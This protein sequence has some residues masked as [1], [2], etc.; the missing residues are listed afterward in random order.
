[1]SKIADFIVNDYLDTTYQVDV[2]NENPTYVQ[3]V[4]H[5]GHLEM[6]LVWDKDDKENLFGIYK[7][8]VELTTLIELSN[9]QVFLN[10]II[11]AK[12]NDVWCTVTRTVGLTD[13][14]I[15]RG[16]L[17]MDTITI[18]NKPKPLEFSFTFTDSLGK[19]S[20]VDYSSG[21]F[22][23]SILMYDN[24]KRISHTLQTCLSDLKIGEIYGTATA[25]RIVNTLAP[26]GFVITGDPM[27]VVALPSLG[28]Y[29]G[30]DEA[31]EELVTTLAP[32]SVETVLNELCRL[33]NAVLIYHNG[34]YCF[35]GLDAMLNASVNAYLYQ[36][37]IYLPPLSNGTLETAFV[38]PRVEIDHSD[39]KILKGGNI[40]F[41]PPIRSIRCNYTLRSGNYLIGTLF[42]TAHFTTLQEI[43]PIEVELDGSDS[44]TS[45]SLTSYFSNSLEL[46]LTGAALYPVYT[47]YKFT[48]KVNTYYL[49]R[50]FNGWDDGGNMIYGDSVWEASAGYYYVVADNNSAFSEIVVPS[51]VNNVLIIEDT[52]PESGTLELLIELDGLIYNLA[53]SKDYVPT[54][55]AEILSWSNLHNSLTVYN[56]QE[57]S[58]TQ[59]SYTAT[60]DANNLKKI[61]YSGLFLEY[62]N[63]NSRYSVKIWDTTLKPT[64]GWAIGAGTAEYL[65]MLT[66]R[67]Q[68][69]FRQTLRRLYNMSILQ[70]ATT[71]L[72]P[73]MLIQYDSS[74][75]NENLILRLEH[76]CRTAETQLELMQFEKGTDPITIEDRSGVD[77]AVIDEDPKTTVVGVINADDP[78]YNYMKT[79]KAVLPTDTQI[80]I[81]GLVGNY[82]EGDVF[83]VWL[84]GGTYNTTDILTC[85]LSAD[86]NSGDKIL[87]VLEVNPDFFLPVGS[88]VEFN[89]RPVYKDEYF[90]P[91]SAAFVTLSALVLPDETILSL[92]AMRRKVR[93][94][95][96]DLKMNYVTQGT[97]KLNYNDFST[98]KSTGK[99]YFKQAL[100]GVR[101]FVEIEN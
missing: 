23:T 45:F 69:E 40:T 4:V 79:T 94:W 7:H 37:N 88:R 85:Y 67:S 63:I 99:I 72:T 15:F 70:Y 52:I 76:D 92:K 75:I 66:L 64:D 29:Q 59:V 49:K 87:N 25:L 1:M 30:S 13:T 39:Y 73:A 47:S 26:D 51:T 101:I 2:Y 24:F 96:N 9:E 21:I 31:D 32:V 35:M 55:D 100:A 3:P 5:F 8:R 74:P 61:E 38:I 36:V 42:D 12:E 84:Y 10:D 71:Y 14:E 27:D 93:V 60:N 53:G 80:H 6:R 33:F 17:L 20:E 28:W 68:V 65:Q 95:Q 16:Y 46:K 89:P 19:A 11:S 43:I 86:A 56:S 44:I 62:A 82:F 41:L 83:K 78:V 91:V 50:S 18:E 54:L 22:A 98:E 77:I 97:A 57:I 90:F 81:T 58:D 34:V 48:I